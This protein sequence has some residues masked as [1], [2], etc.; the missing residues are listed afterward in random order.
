MKNTLRDLFYNHD[1]RLIHK[2]DHYFDIYD[3]YFSK[4]IGKEINILEI[5]I[6]HGGSLQLWKK[7]F[8]DKAN[9]YAI[10][11]NPK[12]K[13]FEEEKVKIFIGSQED[14]LFLREVLLQLPD[15]DIIIDDGGHTMNQ[16]IVSFEA[17]YMKVKEGGMY[18]VE[19]THTSYWR[20]FHGGLKNTNSFI[21]Y[22]KNLIDSLYE[23]HISDKKRLKL[24]EI[25]KHIIGIS[26]Y[27]SIV[28][29]NKMKRPEPFHI[30]KGKE[31]I[32]SI[33]SSE[34]KK[35][36]LLMKYKERFFRK[37]NTFNSNDRGKL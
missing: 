1:G 6:S 17:L 34:P 32:T 26:F 31:T 33:E 36:S 29:F 3:K 4:Y 35:I 18:L 13:E 23:G 7:Y 12:C 16:Q 22:S 19:D 11:I 21:E 28:L 37:N 30:R 10:D 2:W 9:I 14:K 8:G 27:D 15:L 5:G 24:N 25:T 20:G